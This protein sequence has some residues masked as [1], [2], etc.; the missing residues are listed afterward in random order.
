LIANNLKRAGYEV[1]TA[2]NGEEALA[3]LQDRHIDLLLLDVRMPVMDGIT[4]LRRLRSN[5]ATRDQ[6]VVMMTASP[7]AVSDIS[8]VLTHLG[9]QDLLLKPLTAAELAATIEKTLI[10]L[11]GAQA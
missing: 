5:D 1:L 11:R 2:S 10:T 8:P 6:A 7:G 3:I 9:V 4:A